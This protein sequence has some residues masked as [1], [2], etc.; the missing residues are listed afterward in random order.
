MSPLVA[1]CLLL[2][3]GETVRDRFVRT[4]RVPHTDRRLRSEDRVAGSIL[5]SRS[6]KFLSLSTNATLTS[7]TLQT[8]GDSVTHIAGVL[9]RS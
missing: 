7:C 4:R 3:S 9:F 5:Q 1:L 8:C 2:L 6:R